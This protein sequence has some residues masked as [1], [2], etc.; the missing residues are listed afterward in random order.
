MFASVTIGVQAYTSNT[1]FD[2]IRQHFVSLSAVG[3]K[4]QKLIKMLFPNPSY[5]FVLLQM[6]EDV[7]TAN[8]KDEYRSRIDQ[9]IFNKTSDAR[10]SI[11]F[12]CF[13][14]LLFHKG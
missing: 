2:V 5:V 3:P 11:I 10:K 8:V 6:L 4:Q 1:D 13:V 14:I 9:S 12:K 7:S